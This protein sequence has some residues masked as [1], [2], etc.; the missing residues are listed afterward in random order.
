[1][2]IFISCV[3]HNDLP[4]SF[5]S[6]Q[7][8]A[9]ELNKKATSLLQKECSSCH[10]KDSS[11]NSFNSIGSTEEM[12]QLGLIIPGQP[13][14]STLFQSVRS[15]TMPTTYRLSSENINLLSLWISSMKIDNDE[16]PSGLD[17][18]KNFGQIYFQIYQPQKCLICH[19]STASTDLHNFNQTLLYV[20]KG[21]PQFSQIYTTLQTPD[22][23]EHKVST[24]QLQLLSDWITKGAQ[25]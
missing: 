15:G 19:G 24:E 9:D 22:R 4:L 14:N 1:M 23:E 3:A 2:T 7:L 11:N 12:I 18:N 5:N 13:D 6:S 25:L 17:P 21:S 8:S 20:I 16:Q 10:G